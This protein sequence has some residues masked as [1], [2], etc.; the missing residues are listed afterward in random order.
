MSWVAWYVLAAVGEIG[1]CFAFW[2]WLRMDRSSAWIIPG[3]AAL[4]MFAM[5]LTRIPTSSAG[6]A[7]ASYGGVY[8][9][10]SILWLWM[11]EGVAPDRWDLA[12]AALSLLGTSVILFGRR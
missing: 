9:L 1:G 4:I 7:Y 11:A 6:R 2:A 12:G 10:G 8:I 5:A 3:L